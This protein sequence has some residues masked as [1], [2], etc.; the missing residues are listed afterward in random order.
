MSNESYMTYS[1]ASD[2]CDWFGRTRLAFLIWS[3]LETV[4][5]AHVV[6]YIA[7]RTNWYPSVIEEDL[8][9]WR[10]REDN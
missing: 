7:Q 2:F 8:K 6:D 3:G 5:E 10:G 4:T 1:E 9:K